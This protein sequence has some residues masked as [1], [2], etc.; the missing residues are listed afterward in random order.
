MEITK[1][2]EPLSSTK[3][4]LYLLSG[5]ECAFPACKQLMIDQY[6]HYIGEI[7][8]IEAALPEGQRFNPQQTNEERR[9]ISNLVLMCP[10]HHS[11]TDNVVEYPVLRMQQIK[12]DH[13][14]KSLSSNIP[15]QDIQTFI[16]ATFSNYV[17]PLTNVDALNLKDYGLTSEQIIDV[18]SSFINT[19]SRIPYK[20]RILYTH[21]MLNSHGDEYLEFDPREIEIRL[22]IEHHMFMQHSHILQRYGLMSEYDNDDYQIVRQYLTA[23]NDNNKDDQKWFLIILRNNYL[24]DP[25]RLLDIIGNLNFNLLEC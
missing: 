15:E 11:V 10:T 13:E 17:E 20:T 4:T 5:N 2:L 24:N 12:Y 23:P 25:E 3:R 18:V 14:S 7:C 19:I 21:C 9:H 1:R 16:D 6:N 22:R 8:H